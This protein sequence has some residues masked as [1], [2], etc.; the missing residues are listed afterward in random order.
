M[1][2][3]PRPI[4][5]SL[6]LAAAVASWHSF[7]PGA[8]HAAS[9]FAQSDRHAVVLVT[10]DGA[11][12]E[13]MFGGLDLDVL[14]STLRE[15]QRPEDQA[16][17][18]R[19]WAA[20]PDARREKLMPFFWGTLMRQHGSIAGNV[21]LGSQVTLTNRHRFSYPGYA[22]IL[23]GEAHDDT[24]KSNDPIRN[25]YPTVLEE[26]QTRLK[27][28][29]P[30][31]AAFTSWNVFDAIVE[32]REGSLTVNA[33]FEPFASPDPLT[34]ALSRL[35]R[36]TPTPWD[37]VRH[38]VYTFRFAVDHLKRARPRVLY[39]ALGETD[40]WAHDGR[41]DRVLETYART[42]AYLHELWTWLQSDADYR[43]RTHILIST[44][45]G[46]GH[47]PKD[48]RDHGA[49]VEGAQ[50]VWIALASPSMTKRGEWRDHPTLHTNQIAATLA[51]WLG[52][53][54]R[55]LRPSAGAAISGR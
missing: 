7:A 6:V 32:H 39:L 44:D 11:R 41:Y 42:D 19:F 14:K 15:N 43:N 54:W 9:L 13:E 21:R 50:D 34:A 17:Y 25:P 40:D 12:T 27:L 33:G 37:S 48:W 18:K 51:S 20:T 46:R 26:L 31:V 52:I 8:R 49:K 10:L 36:E 53:D 5:L 3:Q 35:Q 38:D 2:L 1:H 30:Q 4:I 28:T 29:A 23:L 16:A 24:I 22:E 45:H 47:T 55:A